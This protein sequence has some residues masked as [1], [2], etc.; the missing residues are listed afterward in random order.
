MAI[1][2]VRVQDMGVLRS[3][4]SDPTLNVK[5][6]Q[7]VRDPRAVYVSRHLVH[8]IGDM[9]MSECDVIKKNLY[10]WRDQP[11]WLRGRHMLLR[12][13]DLAEHPHDVAQKIY[14]FLGLGALPETVRV[15]LDE[16]TNSNRSNKYAYATTRMSMNTAGA[17]R[18]KINYSDVVKIQRYCKRL[19]PMLGYIPILYKRA[20][21]NSD[22]LTKTRLRYFPFVRKK[23]GH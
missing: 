4:V 14:S 9:Q 10:Y 19:L 1:K 11:D 22:I 15:W 21:N 23:I 18:R 8:E 20:L 3:I 5:I 12:Y 6:I 17:W 16:N 2:T 13:E 7:L